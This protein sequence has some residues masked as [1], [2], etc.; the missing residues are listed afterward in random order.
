[1][2]ML[3]DENTTLPS[4]V[5]WLAEQG[6]RIFPLRPGTKLPMIEGWQAKATCDADQLETWAKQYPGSNWAMATGEPSGVLVIDAD[7]S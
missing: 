3:N 5:E 7:G 1:M 4:E 2:Q 6:Y